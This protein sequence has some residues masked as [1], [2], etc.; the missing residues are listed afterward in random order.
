MRGTSTRIGCRN[1]CVQASHLVELRCKHRPRVRPMLRNDLARDQRRRDR[2]RVGAAASSVSRP[3]SLLPRPPAGTRRNPERRRPGRNHRPARRPESRASPRSPAGRCRVLDGSRWSAG[4]NLLRHQPAPGRVAR[5]KRGEL[6]RYC[7]RTVE[8][9]RRRRPGGRLRRRAVGEM[10]RASASARPRAPCRDGGGPA[11]RPQQGKPAPRRHGLD[12]S[13]RRLSAVA[14]DL[15]RRTSTRGR[16]ASSPSGRSAPFNSGCATMPA[17]RRRAAGDPL[18][19]RDV[20]PRGAAARTP[21]RN[22]AHRGTDRGR[23]ARRAHG[24]ASSGF[25]AAGNL[26]MSGRSSAG[27]MPWLSR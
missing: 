1:G 20:P 19:D 4:G 2:Q 5:V 3:G 25:S 8:R 12:D 27:G 22:P 6:G 13:I 17:P 18:V 9:C 10:R 23:A 15:A 24:R 14:R 26:A 21:P 7:C 16:A 11:A